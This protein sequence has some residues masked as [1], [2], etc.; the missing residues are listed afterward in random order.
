MNMVFY[1][2]FLSLPALLLLASCKSI[3]MPTVPGI[4]PYRMVIQQEIGRAHV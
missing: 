4:T 3:E 2:V 1:R